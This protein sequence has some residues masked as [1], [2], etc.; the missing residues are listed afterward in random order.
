MIAN[1]VT[2]EEIQA[3]VANRGYYPIDTPIENYDP[4]F[5]SGCLVGAWTAVF[6][7]IKDMRL[8][9]GKFIPADPDEIPF[10]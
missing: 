6:G 4:G 10:N 9:S 1:N 7:M 3:V 8:K 2:V 5:I